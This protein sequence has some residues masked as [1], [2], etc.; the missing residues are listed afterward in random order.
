MS[1]LAFTYSWKFNRR[2]SLADID[3]KQGGVT[4]MFRA[5]RRSPAKQRGKFGGRRLWMPHDSAKNSNELT[6]AELFAEPLGGVVRET[7]LARGSVSQELFS[8]QTLSEIIDSH[9][10]YRENH[11]RLLGFLMTIE[12]W[13]K[14][15][16]DTAS[17]AR[18]DMLGER[19]TK[20]APAI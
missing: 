13:R 11:L 18:Q 12:Q 14:L 2:S 3:A 20:R 19:H 16:T 5:R 6:R 17:L 7:L 4:R 10:E 1:T 9:I 15:I 8:P